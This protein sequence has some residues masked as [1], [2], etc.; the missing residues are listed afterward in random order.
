MGILVYGLFW[1]LLTTWFGP[2]IAIVSVIAIPAV[3]SLMLDEP[4]TRSIPRAG[5]L[6]VAEAVFYASFPALWNEWTRWLTK[7]HETSSLARWLKNQRI[8]A[9]RARTWHIVI[10]LALGVVGT[11]IWGFGDL[12]V[13]EP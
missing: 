12:L 2:A 9:K 10:A 11:L 5:A 7:D 6:I 13:P 3:F 8:A 4:L 1:L